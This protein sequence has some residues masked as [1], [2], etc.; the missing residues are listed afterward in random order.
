MKVVAGATLLLKNVDLSCGM[1]WKGTIKL[2]NSE[3]LHCAQ[4]IASSLQT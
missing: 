1:R 3:G 4:S 2:R